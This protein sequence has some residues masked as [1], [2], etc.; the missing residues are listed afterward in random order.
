M[1]KKCNQESIQY[2]INT[3]NEELIKYLI[4]K[5]ASFS[6]VVLIK[7]IVNNS[8]KYILNYWIQHGMDINYED[9][10]GISF[11]NYS[12]SIQ[13][14]SMI[15]YLIENYEININSINRN[16]KMI[17]NVIINNK[18]KILKYLIKHHLNIN[19]KDCNGMDVLDYAI[20]A[21]KIEMIKYLIECEINISSQKL[22]SISLMDKIIKED[23]KKLISI[24]CH[25]EKYFKV[26][27]LNDQQS[28]MNYI[29]ENKINNRSLI[30][31]LI[32]DGIYSKEDQLFLAIENNDVSLAKE[33]IH[34]GINLNVESENGTLLNYA[35]QHDNKTIVQYLVENGADINKICTNSN[36]YSNNI[37]LN[38]P[39]LLLAIHHNNE[40][41]VKYLIEKGANT[42]IY[43]RN[44]SLLSLIIERN[45]LKLLKLLNNYGLLLYN[46]S[47]FENYLKESVEN[48]IKNNNSEIVD[49]IINEYMEINEN[50]FLDINIYCCLENANKYDYKE[51]V[52]CFIDAGLYSK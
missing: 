46:L 45:N 12:I 3:H 19:K 8:D 51:L 2:A 7:Y 32:K 43:V 44:Q 17:E 37:N 4:D 24:L 5:N 13:K 6:R 25:H 49:Y 21:E 33:L 18:I 27:T 48:T 28:I 20:K 47:N 10:Y 11:L 16:I 15:K 29:N 26:G 1:K 14:I 9:E 34:K 50:I 40:W 52:K 41:I 30:E 36:S 39:P 23:N 38:Y 35:I 22:I 31:F 42:D